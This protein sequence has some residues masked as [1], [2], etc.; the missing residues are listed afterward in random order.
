MDQP[1]W[2]NY[3]KPR[4]SGY[5]NK[6]ASVITNRVQ[7]QTIFTGY[8][9]QIV[10]INK[11]FR[12]TLRPTVFGGDDGLTV[13]NL[14]NGDTWTAPITLDAIQNPNRPGVER[15]VYDFSLIVNLSRTNTVSFNSS[16]YPSVKELYLHDSQLS[17]IT[18]IPVTL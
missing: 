14:K 4:T 5:T 9:R 3:I 8:T 2:M 13:A 6:N 18:S 10:A 12:T 15:P 7:A 11:G 17:T 16:L 1:V